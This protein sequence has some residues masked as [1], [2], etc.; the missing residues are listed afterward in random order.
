MEVL[1]KVISLIVITICFVGG[2]SDDRPTTPVDQ[3]NVVTVS[4]AFDDG[5]WSQIRI[6]FESIEEEHDG[7]AESG[8]GP[9]RMRS[10]QTGPVRIRV[11]GS[12]ELAR[13]IASELQGSQLW[14]TYF[15]YSTNPVKFQAS[16]PPE[17]ENGIRVSIGLVA[18]F[19][20]SFDLEGF[21]IVTDLHGQPGSI[22]FHREV[23]E[24]ID[25]LVGRDMS[26]SV[27]GVRSGS[28]ADR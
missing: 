16:T 24:S 4:G 17:N 5:S 25:A 10:L 28:S 9:V 14:L 11:T 26:V 22:S 27:R 12:N 3:G 19:D 13:K 21:P 7:I 2:C 6:A 1:S 8:S 23:G 15:G 20:G 18:H